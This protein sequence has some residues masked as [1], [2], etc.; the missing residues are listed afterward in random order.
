M[1]KDIVLKGWA[2]ESGIFFRTI[3][4]SIR[5]NE[6]AALVF[7]KSPDR[8]INKWILFVR[9]FQIEREGEGGIQSQRDYGNGKIFKDGS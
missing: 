4:G 1:K 9:S 5:W 3:Y 2:F 6:K 7:S 8:S